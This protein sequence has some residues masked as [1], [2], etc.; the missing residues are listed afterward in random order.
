MMKKFIIFLFIGSYFFLLPSS[1]SA[2]MKNPYGNVSDTK[3]IAQPAYAKW[4]RM[5]MEK[6]KEKY[7]TAQIVDYEHL[8]RIQG[9]NT[10]LERFKLWLKE[11]EKEFGVLVQIEF[12]KKTERV[13]KIS[14][15][16]GD[17]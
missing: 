2:N 6:T 15:R 7:P 5:A 1:F 17:R 4:G 11:G 16:E 12:D 3:L 14:F 9:I 10:S 8:G 13:I